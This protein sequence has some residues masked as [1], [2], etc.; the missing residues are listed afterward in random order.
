MNALNGCEHSV[1]FKEVNRAGTTDIDLYQSSL[2]HTKN[3]RLTVISM[4]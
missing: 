1:A 2:F 3:A 4:L